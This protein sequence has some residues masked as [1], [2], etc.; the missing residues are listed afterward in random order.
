MLKAFEADSS[1]IT[2]RGE[3]NASSS[4]NCNILLCLLRS[5][6]SVKYTRQ[7]VKCIQFVSAGWENNNGPDKWVRTDVRFFGDGY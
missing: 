1:F 5:P 6:D 7:I 4:A 3:R 2:Y